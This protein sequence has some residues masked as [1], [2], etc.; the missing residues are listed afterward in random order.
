MNQLNENPSNYFP[1]YGNQLNIPIKNSYTETETEKLEKIS[2]IIF[3]NLKYANRE[4]KKIKKFNIILL[5]LYIISIFFLPIEYSTNYKYYKYPE[6]YIIIINIIILLY[7]LTLI[8]KF[9]DNRKDIILYQLFIIINLIGTSYLIINFEFIILLII[10]III[11]SLN[12]ML[13][14]F[15]NNWKIF[16]NI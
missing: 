4:I 12:S 1:S 5:L 8:K 14:I 15:I 6:I 13:F 7:G 10:Y 16:Y 3:D 9:S 11:I 2:N